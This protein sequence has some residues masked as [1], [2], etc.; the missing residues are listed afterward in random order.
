MSLQGRG[1][2]SCP[3]FW[4]F[5]KQQGVL[6]SVDSLYIDRIISLTMIDSRQIISMTDFKSRKEIEF[7]FV[8]II[9]VV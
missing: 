7:M 5:W 4:T 1:Q 3:D 2:S 6:H 8:N 9:T